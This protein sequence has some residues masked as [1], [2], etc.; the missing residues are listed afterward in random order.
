VSM[1]AALADQP[2]GAFKVCGPAG[3]VQDVLSRLGAGGRS[4]LPWR[5]NRRP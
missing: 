1:L 4:R 5:Q 3:A 2:K